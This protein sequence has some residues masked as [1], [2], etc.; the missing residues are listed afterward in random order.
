MPESNYKV[1]KEW[2]KEVDFEILVLEIPRED[3]EDKLAYLARD[4]GNITRSFYEDFVIATCVANI[5]QMLFHMKQLQINPPILMRIRAETMAHILKVNPFLDPSN[6]VINRNAVVKIKGPEGPTEDERPLAENKAWDVSYYDEVIGKEKEDDSEEG[7][8]KV[9]ESNIKKAAKSVEDLEY[10]VTKQWWKRIN[11]YVEVKKF[12]EGDVI[13]ILSQR[14]FHNRSSFQTYIVSVCVV[15]AEDLFVMLDNMGIPNRVTPPILMHEVYELCREINPFLTYENAQ[16]LNEGLKDEEDDEKGSN[17]RKSPNR[18]TTHAKHQCARKKKPK[19]GFKDVSK[20]DL[21]RLG[22]AMKVFVIGQDSAIDDIV[23]AVKRASVGLKD[24]NKPIG[25]FLFAGRTGVGKTLTTKILADELIKDRDNL[26]TIDCSEYSADHEYAKLIGAPSGYVGHEQGGILTNSILENPFSVIVFDEIE[27]ASYKVHELMLQILEEGRLTDGKGQKVSFK[28]CIIVM[29]SNVGV[30]EVDAVKKTVG[31]GDVAKL[32]NE[33]TSKAIDKAI[34]KKFKPEFLNR[35]DS[36]VHFNNLAKEDYMRI[37]DLELFKL[38]ENLKTNDTEYKNL[39]LEFDNKVKNHI[40]TNGIDEEYGARPLKRC[41]EREI[42]NPLA[43]AL[44][45]EEIDANSKVIVSLKRNK[46]HFKFDTEFFQ[47][48][49][50]QEMTAG[51]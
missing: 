22:Q 5:N 40:Y 51:N 4:K 35:I 27:K 31:F 43:T 45:T 25:S 32:T 3:I 23:E 16:E 20:E 50:H 8:K 17:N 33:K 21:L 48:E 47:S 26:V 39:T 44:L 1:H 7:S 19:K 24:P 28:D 13:S 6:L 42:S 30:S 41:I 10:G 14:Y 36:V 38:N 18:M 37:I 15:D 11:K 34:K 49:E 29:T 46:I 12:Q 2:V 9:K